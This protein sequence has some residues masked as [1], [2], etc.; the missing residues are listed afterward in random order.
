M[1]WIAWR[2]ALGGAVAVTVTRLSAREKDVSCMPGTG[3]RAVVRV[4]MQDVQLSGTEKVAVYAVLRF[5]GGVWELSFVMVVVVVVVAVEDIVLAF[6]AE[7]EVEE[8][9]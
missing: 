5:R 2:I 4:S 8:V 6:A 9:E 1:D 3:E 7:V